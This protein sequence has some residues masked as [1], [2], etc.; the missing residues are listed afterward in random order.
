MPFSSLNRQLL[1]DI[2][3]VLLSLTCISTLAVV[4]RH[5]PVYSR[6]ADGAFLWLWQ[7]VVARATGTHMTTLQKHTGAL[8]A[9]AHS[10]AG[11]RHAAL[12]QVEFTHTF[13]L[14]LLEL[15]QHAPLSL[16][17]SV[18]SV[19]LPQDE[20]ER[21]AGGDAEDDGQNP[22]QSDA[23][24]LLPEKSV[25]VQPGEEVLEAL[26]GRLDLDQVVVQDQLS[27]ARDAV[28]QPQHLLGLVDALGSFTADEV[29]DDVGQGLDCG[30]EVLISGLQVQLGGV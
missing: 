1:T 12:L 15:L 5:H 13:L 10:T 11:G 16:T 3:P 14:L 6:P 27:H 22:P 4:K 18:V 25:V 24:V 2:S 21:R 7:G 28:P 9:Q 17:L 8:P 23:V 20:D 19:S 26:F 29:A 30:V